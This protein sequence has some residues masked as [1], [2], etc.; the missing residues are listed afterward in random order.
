MNKEIYLEFSNIPR[1]TINEDTVSAFISI[2]R[3]DTRVDYIEHLHDNIFSCTAALD[4]EEKISGEFS[5]GSLAGQLYESKKERRERIAE[6][7]ARRLNYEKT[8][9][10]VKMADVEKFIDI[11]KKNKATISLLE[12]YHD[13]I[14]SGARPF[15]K[16]WDAAER[17][18]EEFNAYENNGKELGYLDVKFFR[19][20][21]DELREA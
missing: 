9:E 1:S 14:F 21:L 20:N 7:E 8:L 13:V 18:F 15:K 3:S 12:R 6:S 19:A 4:D 17:T 5:L 16:G 10:A 11:A 2:A